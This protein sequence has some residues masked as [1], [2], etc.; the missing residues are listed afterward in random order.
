MRAKQGWVPFVE[1]LRK[2][3]MKSNVNYNRFTNKLLGLPWITDVTGI[4]RQI[5][6]DFSN[7]TLDEL[8]KNLVIGSLVKHTGVQPKH[9]DNPVTISFY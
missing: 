8:S 5:E 6:Y 9:H 3:Q 2:H 4:Y 1:K 7:I